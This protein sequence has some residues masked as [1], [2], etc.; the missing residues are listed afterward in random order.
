[1]T[2]MPAYAIIQVKPAPRAEKAAAPETSSPPVK[3]ALWAVLTGGLLVL[4]VMTRSLI[5]QLRQPPKAG[6]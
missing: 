6:P 4:A 2:S 3:W 5:Q 1:M